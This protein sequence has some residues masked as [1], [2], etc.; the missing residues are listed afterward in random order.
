MRNLSKVIIFSLFLFFISLNS[1]RADKDIDMV[2]DYPHMSDLV[3]SNDIYVKALEKVDKYIDYLD[4]AGFNYFIRLDYRPAYISFGNP[5]PEFFS[6]IDITLTRSD[7]VFQYY[8]LSGQ[9]KTL[10]N[11]RGNYSYNL[12]INLNSDS[13]LDSS[14]SNI[15]NFLSTSPT[16]TNIIWFK[17]YEE[18]FQFN[19]NKSLVDGSFLIPQEGYTGSLSIPYATNIKPSTYYVYTSYTFDTFPYNI[20]FKIS[21]DNYYQFDM[22]NGF[23]TFKDNLEIINQIGFPKLTTTILENETDD[24]DRLI[25]T[26]VQFSFDIY[27][28]SK[29][30]YEISSDRVVFETFP[31]NNVVATFKQ[32]GTSFFK[33]TELSTGKEVYYEFVLD[34]INETSFIDEGT[35][36]LDLGDKDYTDDD[37][38][39]FDEDVDSPTSFLSKVFTFF[40][41][42]F[43]FI[44]QFGKIYNL[45]QK[46]DPSFDNPDYFW[47]DTLRC[48]GA[49]EVYNENEDDNTFGRPCDVGVSAY[50]N[51][52]PSIVINPPFLKGVIKGRFAVIDVGVFL[53]YRETYFFWV[54]LIVG[55]LTLLKVFDTFSKALQSS[56][57]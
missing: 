40:E 42:K 24:E 8:L 55:S 7:N 37:I 35:N 10:S 11:S 2:I 56:N 1:V 29:Y 6:S 57:K 43:K 3:S 48:P 34:S 14:L 54:R 41:D 31:Q 25:S 44:S 4:E 20:K 21:D 19:Y 27:D 23:L 38:G 22:S 15:D 51:K 45:W 9:I 16:P 18:L 17:S 13:L 26:T 32:N 5:V 33:V 36:L 46:Y 49:G 53:E 28:T 39:D 47:L 52:L 12:N 30:L 50:K